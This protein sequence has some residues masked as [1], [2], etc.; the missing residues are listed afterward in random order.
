MRWVATAQGFTE[1]VTFE[2]DLQ[3]GWLTVLLRV[4][5]RLNAAHLPTLVALD[6]CLGPVTGPRSTSVQGWSE[7]G[8]SGGFSGSGFG[9]RRMALP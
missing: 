3:G 6:V 8:A 5:Q 1:E 7:G 9:A 4:L 2:L